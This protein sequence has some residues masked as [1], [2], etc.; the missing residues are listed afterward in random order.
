MD[1]IQLIQHGSLW[2]LLFGGTFCAAI[3]ILGRINAEMLINDYP[4]DI[5]AK[6]GPMSSGARKQASLASIPLLLALTAVIVLALH[7]LRQ[8]EGGLT[9]PS[10]FVVVTVMLQVWNLI[11]LVI[12]DWLIL[13]TLRPAFMIVPGTAGY[14]DYRFHFHKFL[15]GIVLTLILSGIITLVALGMELVF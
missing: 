11:D 6:A 2:G 15:N 7:Q 5:R 1:T 13:M 3:L 8:A 10:T 4:P 9:L 14:H 12:L